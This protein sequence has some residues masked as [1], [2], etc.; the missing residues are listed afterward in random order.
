MTSK[1]P[2]N[3]IFYTR[4]G[5]VT[6]ALCWIMMSILGALPFLISGE[7]KG[8]IDALFE[9]VSGFTT[10]G[11]SILSDVESMSRCIL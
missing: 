11:A 10:T 3:K 2:S 1:K 8:V 9:T 6:V 5:F 4:E 7:I